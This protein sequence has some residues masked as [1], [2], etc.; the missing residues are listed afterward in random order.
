MPYGGTLFRRTFQSVRQIIESAEIDLI[1]QKIS[2]K[3]NVNLQSMNLTRKRGVRSHE[4]DVEFF[5]LGCTL[6][7]H[8]RRFFVAIPV[9]HG[10]IARFFL[11]QHTKTGK[12]YQM[13]T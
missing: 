6:P 4:T 9:L 7:S 2:K 12:L 11:V 10:R 5:F 3:L 13:T 1:P 8:L